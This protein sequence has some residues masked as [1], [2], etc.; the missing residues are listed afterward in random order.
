MTQLQDEV[1]VKK[2]EK[3]RRGP[4]DL[5]HVQTDII[6]LRRE[7]EVHTIKGLYKEN[8]T[9]TILRLSKMFVVTIFRPSAHTKCRP[10]TFSSTVEPP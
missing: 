7:L 9:Q 3:D 5:T 8:A 4:K 6:K 2:E 10:L 1:S